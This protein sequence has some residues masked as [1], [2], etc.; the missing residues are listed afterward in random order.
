MA[1]HVNWLTSPGSLGDQGVD[2]LTS[3]DNRM[4]LI[5]GTSGSSREI[6]LNS[7]GHTGSEG[8]LQKSLPALEGYI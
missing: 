5:Y 6:A 4:F 7:T 3:V 1:A 2:R 8:R